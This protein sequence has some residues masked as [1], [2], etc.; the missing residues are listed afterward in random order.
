MK[1]LL[2][3]MGAVMG[4]SALWIRPARPDAHPQ[5]IA[6]H[7]SPSEAGIG[8][9][10]SLAPI[11]LLDNSEF[12]FDEGV[13]VI[14]LTS[15]TCPIS[16][17]LTDTTR[18]LARS[19]KSKGV[20]FVM[21]N[22]MASETKAEV[23]SQANGFGLPYA[24]STKLAELLGAKTTTEVFVLDKSQTLVYRGA[25]D[26]Q[27][28]IAATRPEPTHNYLEDA[29][30]AVTNGQSPAVSATVAPGCALAL[31]STS[32]ELKPTYHNRISRII[33]DNC[34]RCH[35][36]DGVA[37]FALETYAQVSERARMLEVI[38]QS[39][40]MPPWS[41]APAPR[42]SKWS[43]DASL[44]D[45]DLAAIKDWAEAGA[46]EGDPKDAPQPRQWPKEWTIGKPDL[47]LQLPEAIA[48]KSDGVMDYQYVRIDPGFKEDKWVSAM[49]ILPTD[50]SVVHHVLVFLVPPGQDYASDNRGLGGFFAGYVPG[51]DNQVVPAG[52]AKKVPAGTRFEFQIHYTPNGKATKDQLRMG[53]QF[54]DK[55]PE[56]ELR[57]IAVTTLLLSIPPYADNHK[58]VGRL[59]VLRDTEIY[60]F[61]P[62]MH[63]RGKAYRY[64]VQ[65]PD[66]RTELLLDIPK[67]DF[68]WQLEYKLREPKFVPKGSRII[69][70]AWYDNSDKNPANPD[71][72]KRVTWGEQTSDEMMLGYMS[73]AQ[74]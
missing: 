32:N 53:L 39:R 30:R 60:S 55:E 19:W 37:P 61:L 64:E 59:P 12:K 44:S 23:Q 47:V 46:P 56:R 69:G 63:V 9:L 72:S 71:P 33:Q 36:R 62:H 26:D 45:E 70:T 6:V 51:N 57:T 10:V 5:D 28:S 17:K 66:G 22:P 52:L 18:R 34:L 50:R 11:R 20:R 25:I 21:V 38:T 41:A 43:N 67:Y 65:Y 54:T 3:L 42:P 2:I 8:R 31:A 1:I 24:R 15:A 49:Q 40:R 4:G 29:L 13:T 16:K 48:V 68:N 27:Y 74:R 58:V 14:A 35:N 7:A 73:F